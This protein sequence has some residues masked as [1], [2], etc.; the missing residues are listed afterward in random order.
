MRFGEKDPQG[1]RSFRMNICIMSWN[2]RGLGSRERRRMPKDLTHQSEA[3]IVLVQ[4]LKLQRVDRDII[5]DISCFHRTGWIS[6]LST[7]ASGGVIIFW[8]MDR[9]VVA[10]SRADS[11]SATVIGARI[12]GA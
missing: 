8:D 2:A 4:K 7:G 9:L 3:K 11:F 10:E 6:V 12:R 5:S 1:K